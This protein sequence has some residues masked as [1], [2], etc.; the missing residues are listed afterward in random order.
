[1]FFECSMKSFFRNFLIVQCSLN[2]FEGYSI[3]AKMSRSKFQLSVRKKRRNL[4][5]D[6]KMKKVIDYA[7]KNPK[8]GCRVIAEHFSIGKTCVSNIL[9]NAKT[10]QREYEFFK[11]NR[12]KLRHGLYHLINEILIAWYKKCASV[13]VF[14][15]GPML[16]EEA[17]L[18]KERLNKDE[19]ATFTASNGWLEKFK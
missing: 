9:R 2:L 16:K 14:P 18:I 4:S 17:M 10:L 1:M 6:K 5:L 7:N 15:D 19:L 12:K 3:Q 8:M 13:N 11:G